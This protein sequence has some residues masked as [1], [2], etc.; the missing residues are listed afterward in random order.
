[1]PRERFSGSN[2]YK[3]TRGK[4][5]LPALAIFSALGLLSGLM[6]CVIANSFG[7]LGGFIT[8]GVFGVCIGIALAANQMIKVWE[9]LVLPVPAAALYWLSVGV[10]G[11][12]EYI[13]AVANL[14]VTE[15]ASVS[16]I[17]VFGAGVFGGGLFLSGISCLIHPTPPLT[18]VIG[19]S[20][21]W[22]LLSGSLG[23][24]GWILGPSLGMLVWG[25][26]HALGLTASME[27][28]QNA[29]YSQ[30]SHQF[31]TF[32]VWQT[33]MALVLGVVLERLGAESEGS[34]L[35]HPSTL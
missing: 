7:A 20:L 3:A 25:W 1:M 33:G 30:T 10:G 28:F 4:C 31:S 6:T 15:Y 13:L 9:V 21:P 12:I 34:G 24:I 8:G 23:V 16:L 26:L 35:A 29:L 5:G 27:T 2:N 22:S 32:V 19:K 11:L 14:S 18:R 17:S